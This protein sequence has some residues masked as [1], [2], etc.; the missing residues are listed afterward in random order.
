MSNRRNIYIHPK[1]ADASVNSRCQ[2]TI[3]IYDG[4]KPGRTKQPVIILDDLSPWQVTMIA[5]QCTDAL[6]EIRRRV[7]QELEQ[8]RGDE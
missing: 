1:D 7:N 5:K 6:R 4:W 3:H 2:T 8:A